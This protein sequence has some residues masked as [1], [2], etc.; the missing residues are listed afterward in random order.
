[1]TEG[2]KLSNNRRPAGFIPGTCAR[3]G[4]RE[5]ELPAAQGRSVTNDELRHT[6]EAKQGTNRRGWA[7]SNIA[8]REGTIMQATKQ[9]MK[10][11]PDPEPRRQQQQQLQASGSG[12]AA[13]PR[14]KQA[15]K[16][17]AAASLLSTNDRVREPRGA[18][19]S[20]IF[21]QV[22]VASFES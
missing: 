3:A 17:K 8:Q 5:C 10:P 16:P 7:E 18:M 11:A 22:H 21:V 6:R 13:Q 20:S 14:K 19:Y 2:A 1:M 4:R 12:A 15:G 9:M